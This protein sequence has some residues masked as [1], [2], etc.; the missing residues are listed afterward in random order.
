M[1]TIAAVTALL[2]LMA[3]T[4]PGFAEEGPFAPLATSP[5]PE[6]AQAELDQLLA[7]IALYPDE[8]LAQVLAASTY[9]LEVVALQRWLERNPDLSGEALDQALAAQ[10]W[11]ASVKALAPFGSVV[12]MMNGELEWTQRLGN[13][14]IAREAEVMDAVQRL[15][16]KAREAGSLQDNARERVIVE[17][18]A[19]AIEPVEPEVVY[20]PVYDPRVVY[21]PWWWPAYPPYAWSVGYFGGWDFVA[22][23]IYFGLG[24]RVR[25]GGFDRPYA[26]WRNHGL[27]VRRPGPP[28]AWNHDPIHRGGVPYPDPRTRDRF[29][30]IDRDRVGT[31]QDFRGFDVWPRLPSAPP[32]QQQPPQAANPMARGVPQGSARIASRPAQT[33]PTGASPLAPVPRVNAQQH[34]ERGRESLGSSR[35]A[36]PSRSRE[37]R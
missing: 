16:R 5:S 2:L 24:V 14:F 1:K 29:H 3:P 22:G 9:P 19:I 35:P 10:P 37:K 11:D 33:A 30:A 28:V 27:F 13:A 23:G 36:P 32:R 21:G 6:A 15:R 17:P 31:R 20:V 26:D 8:L 7:P 4:S 25:H 18:D 34:S 12:A